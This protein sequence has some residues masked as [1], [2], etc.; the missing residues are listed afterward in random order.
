MDV[1]VPETGDQELAAGIDY[2]PAL[3]DRYFA[4]LSEISNAGTGDDNSHI[5]LRRPAGNIDDREMSQ[6]QSF[7]LRIS[8]PAREEQGGRQEKKGS[9][10]YHVRSLINGDKRILRIVYGR[11]SSAI[12][13]L[14]RFPSASSAFS[15]ALSRPP[16]RST[17][18]KTGAR[19]SGGT[20]APSKDFPVSVKN[21]SF[22]S[23]K[24][25]PL[26]NLRANISEKTP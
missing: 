6:D 11:G 23:P 13:L 16:S 21:N 15:S 10:F 8:S 2:S 3:R 18:G 20:P 4:S 19:I 24:V 5:R 26:G 9:D 17:L 22:G 1:H 7:L 14:Y 12:V 25:Q